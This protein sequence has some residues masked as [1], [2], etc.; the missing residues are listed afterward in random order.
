MPQSNVEYEYSNAHN[1]YESSYLFDAVVKVLSEAKLTDQR[2]FELGCGNGYHADQLSKLGYS[3]TAIDNSESGIKTAQAAFPDCEFAVASAYDDLQQ[4]FGEFG[5]VISLEVVEHLFTPR[6][7]AKRI[8]DMLSDD[9][10]A[11]ISTPYHGYWKNLAIALSNKFDAHVDPLWDGGH[12]KF[13]SQPTLT[14]LLEEAGF[15]DITFIRVG[16]IAPLAKSMI[17]VARKR[18]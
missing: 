14:R 11:I 4:E 10:L 17:A 15:K 8:F 6:T 1:T 7:Y 9:G 16:R 5:C 3:I 18:A 2:L 12:I 13:W